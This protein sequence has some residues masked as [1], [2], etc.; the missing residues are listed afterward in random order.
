MLVTPFI[1][2]VVGPVINFYNVYQCVH[3]NT[4]VQVVL[5]ADGYAWSF[6]YYSVKIRSKL[7]P[8]LLLV[9]VYHVTNDIFIACLYTF[10][11]I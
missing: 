6:M 8:V 2:Q 3:V 5:Y 9:Y 10:S 11:F 4:V 1:L 7:Y